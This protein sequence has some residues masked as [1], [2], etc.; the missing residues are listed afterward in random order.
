MKETRYTE[1]QIIKV[2][3]EVEG[4]RKIRNV[5]RNSGYLMQLTTNGSRSTVI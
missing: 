5:F 2:Q 4:G 3:R 1:S